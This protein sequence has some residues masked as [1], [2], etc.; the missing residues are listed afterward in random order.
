MDDHAPSFWPMNPRMEALTGAV[1]R[2]HRSLCL[3][4]F[5]ERHIW[6]LDK[7]SATGARWHTWGRSSTYTQ[8]WYSFGGAWGDHSEQSTAPPSLIDSNE[9]AWPSLIRSSFMDT[10]SYW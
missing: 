9:P 8:E 5:G 3:S 1:P 4:P 7:V 6:P 2:N 10:G